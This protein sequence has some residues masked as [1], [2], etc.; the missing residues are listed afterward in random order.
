M[1]LKKH[2]HNTLLW[3]DNNRPRAGAV[4]ETYTYIKKAF[5]R[6]S[7]QYVD[8]SVKNEYQ[9]RNV[10]LKNRKLSTFW[11]V[12]KRHRITKVKS[13]LCATDYGEFHSDVKQAL[14]EC[15]VEQNHDNHMVEQYYN[16]DCCL[17]G[18]DEVG[19]D[20]IYRLTSILRKGKS[21][22]LDGIT[23]EHLIYG[24]SSLLCSLL[25]SV[26]WR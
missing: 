19:Q 3:N 1:L 26:S 23:D 18:T 14:A 9:K 15:T 8:R 6:R 2:L 13:S 20:Q 10:M 25:A 12:I 16:D 11:N 21:L 17:M 22:E 5:R 24:K 4:H 7:R